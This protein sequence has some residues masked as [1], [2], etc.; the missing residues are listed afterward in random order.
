[1]VR[2]KQRTLAGGLAV[3]LLVA[4]LSAMAVGAA[5]GENATDVT[6]VVD[7]TKQGSID[8]GVPEGMDHMREAEIQVD[9]YF[10]AAFDKNGLLTAT[11]NFESLKDKLAEYSEKRDT[12][13]AEA[14]ALEA[15]KVALSLSSN[16]DKQTTVIDG[17]DL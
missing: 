17:G 12:D 1:M 10:V 16:P 15:E 3:M 9:G 11:A 5:Y 2:L 4:V 8:V 14:L 6:Y 7:T 13:T